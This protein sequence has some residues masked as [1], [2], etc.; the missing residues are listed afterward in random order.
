MSQLTCTRYDDAGAFLHRM[1]DPL[2]RHET[3]NS[4][5]LG[6]CL[7]LERYPERIERQPYFATVE[8]ARGPAAAPAAAGA[9][10]GAAIMTP[11]YNLVIYGE[12]GA[13]PAPW[14]PVTADL[15]QAN[16]PVPGVLG[17]SEA[18]QA[19]A[20]VWT[21]STGIP[22]RA[23]MS[24]RVYELRQ[25]TPPPFP[26]G[27]LRPATDADLDL[28]V[29]WMLAFIR[30]TGVNDPVN[31]VRKSA[32]LKIAD[33]LLYLWDVDGAPVSMAGQTRPGVHG[34]SIGPV[35][36]PPEHR[37]HGYASACVAALSQQLLDAGYAFCSLFTDLANPTSNSIYQQIGYRPVCDFN[38]Y[39]FTPD[40]QVLGPSTTTTNK[41]RATT[42][43]CRDDLA[44]PPSG[45]MSL[46]GPLVAVL[47]IMQPIP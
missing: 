47:G 20:Q 19:F 5:M 6:I 31:Q 44:Y 36:T 26:G 14:R 42:L 38:E 9:A 46:F 2:L 1:R 7:R 34:I 23:G 35:Y 17:P 43:L 13:D 21:E 10:A 30:D 4:L 32:G 29:A 15:L 40:P 28:V 22:Y 41:L 39:L 16:W 3:A 12:R 37:R 8:D 25:V 24:E 33:R 11:P 45:R 18:S 27:R